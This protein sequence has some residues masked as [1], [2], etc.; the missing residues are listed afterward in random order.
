[1]AQSTRTPKQLG[2]ELRRYRKQRKLTQE[3][4]SSLTNK[5]Q[6]TI[7]TLEATG[8]GTLEHCSPS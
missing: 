5:R 8:T 4:L 6:A 7:S 2:G 1:M 3:G